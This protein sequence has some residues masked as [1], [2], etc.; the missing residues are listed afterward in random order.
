MQPAEDALMTAY[1]LAFC[2][3]D[4]RI[5]IDSEADRS[6][7]EGC[8]HAVT[9]PLQMNE[10]GWRYPLGIFDKSIKASSDGHEN[11]SLFS[12]DIHNATAHLAMRCYCPECLAPFFQPVIQVT[13]RGK[14]GNGL[15]E[16]VASI[17]DILLDL[18]LLPARRGI[19]ELWLEQVMAGHCLEANVDIPLLAGADLVYG[20]AHVVIDAAPWNTT[21]HAEGMV[22]GVEQHLVG[23][24]D[25]RGR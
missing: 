10:T 20:S 24:Q 21:K 18:S 17:L 15:P 6:V 12:P 2:R 19:A 7:G 4:Q 9:V 14:A 22:V 13:K 16:P 5:R 23:L 8:A 25:R 11:L 1:D 3:G